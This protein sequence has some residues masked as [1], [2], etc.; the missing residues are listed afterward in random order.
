[1]S[2]DGYVTYNANWNKIISTQLINHYNVC[3]I[4][5]EITIKKT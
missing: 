1:M 5:I 3:Y 4:S 2:E